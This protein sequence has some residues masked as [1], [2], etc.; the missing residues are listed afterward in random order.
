VNEKDYIKLGIWVLLI[1]GAFI[2]LWR[3]GHIG[4]IGNY[5]AETREE[6]KK[7]TWPSWHE[8]KGSTVVVMIS[9]FI[10]GAFTVGIDFIIAMFVRWMT[11]I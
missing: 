9:I 5:V 10:L 6:L 11:S 4:R 3:K 2:F 1:G 7:C 8:L